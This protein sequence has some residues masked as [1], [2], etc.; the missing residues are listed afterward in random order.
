MPDEPYG[1]GT[2]LVPRSPGSAFL[3]SLNAGPSD[4]DETPPETP[5]PATAQLNVAGK[6]PAPKP[7]PSL[8]G[9]IGNAAGGALSAVGSALNY[10]REKL[11]EFT[12]KYISSSM[13]TPEADYKNTDSGRLLAESLLPPEQ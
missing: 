1:S 10:P 2:G 7:K 6:P 8:L 12:K 9:S 4:P 5:N 13:G 3:D 11:D